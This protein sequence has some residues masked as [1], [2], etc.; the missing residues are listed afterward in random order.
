MNKLFIVFSKAY[1]VQGLLIIA[2]TLFASLLAYVLAA[3]IGIETLLLVVGTSFLSF[4]SMLSDENPVMNTISTVKEFRRTHW[5]GIA[6]SVAFLVIGFASVFSSGKLSAVLLGL[7]I[8][9]RLMNDLEASK[10]A[11]CYGTAFLDI[12]FFVVLGFGG[13]LIAYATLL[14]VAPMAGVIMVVLTVVMSRWVHFKGMRF[15]RGYV[16]LSYSERRDQR[17]RAVMEVVKQVLD[18][19]KIFYFDYTTEKLDAG[20]DRSQEIDKLLELSVSVADATIEV[21]SHDTLEF[22]YSSMVLDDA[23]YGARV[24]QLQDWVQVEREHIRK[25]RSIPVRYFLCMDRQYLRMMA[26]P[27]EQERIMRLPSC[28]PW[29]DNESYCNHEPFRLDNGLEYYHSYEFK[30]GIDRFVRNLKQMPS[31][32]M[33]SSDHAFVRRFKEK[34]FPYAYDKRRS[35]SCNKVVWKVDKLLLG[36][37][38]L[39]AARKHDAALARALLVFKSVDP[40]QDLHFIFMG[41]SFQGSVEAARLFV[42]AMVKLDKIKALNLKK[43]DDCFKPLSIEISQHCLSLANVN[44]ST[45]ARSRGYMILAQL[46][47]LESNSLDNCIPRDFLRKAAD[48]DQH[49]GYHVLA[50][51]FEQRV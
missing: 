31:L 47:Y 1:R 49:E 44:N 15:P 11:K 27:E 29:S 19:Y 37:F 25:N 9:I 38:Q 35:D 28:E 46:G 51:M 21:V 36:I 17:G 30:M 5:S 33:S 12:L 34:S 39:V 18:K 10:H 16:F 2:A 42:L 4:W 24:E 48:L 45:V 50:R 3:D 43:H 41:W 22:D 23:A 8:G 7:A 26:R 20:A 14:K 32:S 40:G 13:S 6:L